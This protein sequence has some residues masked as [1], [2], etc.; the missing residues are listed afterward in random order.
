MH[1]CIN[2]RANLYPLRYTQGGHLAGKHSIS[3]V[4]TPSLCGCT[5]P[6]RVLALACACRKHVHECSH[7]SARAF[8]HPWGPAHAVQADFVCVLPNQGSGTRTGTLWSEQI[9]R[10]ARFTFIGCQAAAA[11]DG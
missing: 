7:T 3:Q 10:W 2:T 5:A 8:K 9:F 6:A 1:A 11:A 4:S